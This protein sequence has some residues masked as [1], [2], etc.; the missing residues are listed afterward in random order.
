MLPATAAGRC[1]RAVL[2]ATAAGRCCRV[3][4]PAGEEK[5]KME[6]NK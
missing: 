3:V 4:L 2:P 1:C 6:S 5:E